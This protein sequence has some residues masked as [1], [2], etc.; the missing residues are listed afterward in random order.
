MMN[1][2]RR[3]RAKRCASAPL[4]GV[5]LASAWDFHCHLLPAVDDG[6]R[7]LEETRAAIAG[8]SALGYRG[9]VLTPHIYPGVYDNTSARLRASFRLL[10]QAVDD[11]FTLRLAAEYF[12][13]EA[14]LAA[15][16]RDDVLYLEL[17]SQKIVLVEFPALMPAPAGMDALLRLRSAG[18]QPVL[19][20]VERCCYV[21]QEQALWLRRLE[22]SG[23][24]LQCDIG[25]LTGQYGPEPQSFARR[26]LDSELPALWGTDLHRVGQ[27]DRYIAPGLALLAKSGQPVNTVL[28]ELGP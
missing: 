7:S 25:S 16:D 19:A 20:H 24:W 21:R 14:L 2:L 12:A 11:T 15:I 1:L 23:V 3:F 27:V 26:L 5:R 4:D 6:L 18:Y 13:D 9:A 28:E 22:H 8:L 10:Q 17:G